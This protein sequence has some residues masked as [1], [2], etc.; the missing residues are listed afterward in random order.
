MIGWFHCD[1]QLCWL[2][3]WIRVYFNFSKFSWINFRNYE[4][5]LSGENLCGIKVVKN[6]KTTGTIHFVK[7][8]LA[9]HKN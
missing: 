8:K 4:F 9:Q 2:G 7:K 5:Q 3:N 1:F 6:F